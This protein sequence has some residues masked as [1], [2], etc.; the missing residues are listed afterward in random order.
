MS[1]GTM[2]CICGKTAPTKYSYYVGNM[3]MCKCH[4]EKEKEKPEK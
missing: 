3:C 1:D 2:T 4:E